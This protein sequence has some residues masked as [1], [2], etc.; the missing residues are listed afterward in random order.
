M[1]REE[2]VNEITFGT[3]DFD[4]VVLGLLCQGRAGDEI[5]NLFLDTFLVQ[6]FRLERVDRRLDGA[7]RNL[8]RAVGITTGVEDLHADLAARLVHRAGHDL[9]LERFFLGSQLGC[10]G[11]N[12]TLVVRADTASDHQAHTTTGTLGEVRRH[13][14]EAT[15]LF[16]QTGVHRAHQGAVAQRGKTQVQRGQ[17]VRVMSGGHR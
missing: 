2:L 16:F 7:W 13:A 11:V 9:V 4:A 5:A 8:L 14:L 1:G 17:Q 15:R 12:A 3:H 6:L 10:A